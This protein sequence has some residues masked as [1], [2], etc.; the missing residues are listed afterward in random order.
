MFT[1]VRPL[2]ACAALLLLLVPGTAQAQAVTQTQATQ[3]AMT[4][5]DAL[6]MLQA[7]NE[8]FVNGQMLPRNYQ[9]QVEA[10]AT[11]QYPF[12]VVLGCIDSRVP[13]E[14]VFDQ[15]IGDIFAP[16]IAG[17]F[18]NTDILGSMEFATAVA[19]SKLIVVLGHSSCGAVKGACDHVE[20]GNLT[21]TLANIAPAIYAVTDVAGER[22]SKN[23][24]YV[25]AV[26][27][28]NVAMTVQNILDR[29]PV[30]KDL[31]DKGE[32]MVVGAMYDVATGRVTF[33]E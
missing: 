9:D 12:A 22:S 18:V 24:S 3:A 28:E 2:L 10:T 1:S 31:V 16:R 32:V 17:N 26:T 7:G 33:M 25:E 15:G 13:P 4:P 11:G 29:S 5:A 8:R 14:I 27:H 6:Q 20:L 19:G 30:I 21:H 23:A